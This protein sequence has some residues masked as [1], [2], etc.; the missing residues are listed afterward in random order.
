M[1][2]QP[3]EIELDFTDD[4]DNYVVELPA[5]KETV[6]LRIKSDRK[7]KIVGCDKVE[8]QDI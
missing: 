2:K 7:F 8:N 5:S 1:K 4:K 3:I 6:V